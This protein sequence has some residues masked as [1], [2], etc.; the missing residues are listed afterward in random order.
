MRYRRYS[1]RQRAQA[2]ASLMLGFSVRSVARTMGIPRGTLRRWKVKVR[3]MQQIAPFKKAPAWLT[4]TLADL[5]I[6]TLQ[7]LIISVQALGDP[8]LI[9]QMSAREVVLVHGRLADQVYNL[10]RAV[11]GCRGKT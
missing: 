4:P 11:G 5:V 7:S 6:E 2:M 9:R 1:D 8:R 3:E 10:L